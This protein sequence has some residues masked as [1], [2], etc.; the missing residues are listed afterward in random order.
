MNKERDDDLAID[1]LRDYLKQN[2]YKSTLD[3]LDK[4]LKVIEYNEKNNKNKVKYLSIIL[5][6]KKKN[7]A[8]L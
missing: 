7:Q 4:E 2:G 1:A 6:N 8:D 3:C 5:R